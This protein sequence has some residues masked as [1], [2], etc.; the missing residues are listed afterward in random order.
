MTSE[1][2]CWGA[3]GLGSIDTSDWGD[4][5]VVDVEGSAKGDLE[6]SGDD[7]PPC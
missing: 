2:A 7:W 4:R 1:V 3:P 5:G 6:L